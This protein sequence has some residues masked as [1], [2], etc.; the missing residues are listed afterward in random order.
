MRDK[1]TQGMLAID[2]SKWLTLAA[3]GGIQKPS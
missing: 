3:A 2:A 1:T